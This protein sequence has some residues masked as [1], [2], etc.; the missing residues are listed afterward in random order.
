MVAQV[1]KRGVSTGRPIQLASVTCMPMAEV[2]GGACPIPILPFPSIRSL[3]DVPAEPPR[4]L[5]PFLEPRNRSSPVDLARM[6]KPPESENAS[7]YRVRSEEHKSELQALMRI[8]Y[9]VF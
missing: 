2:E 9:A 7:P 8:S 5:M 4:R 1:S 3:T 6:L